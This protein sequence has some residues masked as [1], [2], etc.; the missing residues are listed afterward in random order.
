MT[1]IIMSDSTDPFMSLLD[2]PGEGDEESSDVGESEAAVL[3]AFRQEIY[4]R[5][6]DAGWGFEAAKSVEHGKTDQSLLNHV[7][8]GVFGLA[9][10]DELVGR[11]DG[12]RLD[13]ADL[14]AAMALFTIHDIHKLDPERDSNPETRFD[15]PQEEVEEYVERFGLSQFA[16]RLD[17]RDFQSCAIDHHDDWTANPDGTTVT[18]DELRPFVR[19]ADALA[20][21][22]TPEEATASSVQS[23]V[24]AAYPRAD[25]ELRC[26]VLDDVKGVFTNLIN[27]ATA[28]LLETAGYERLLVYQD[29][30]VY[31]APGDEETPAMDDAFFEQLGQQL[32]TGVQSSHSAYQSPRRLSGN[33][34]TRSQ[35][36]YGI[37][38][39]DFFYAGPRAVLEA[40]GLKG[41]GDA[42]PDS[43]PTDSM[44]ETMEALEA[45]LPFD[46]DRN[47]APVGYA[48]IVYTV[49]RAFVDP[50]LDAR[51]S[52]TSALAAT[53]QIFGASD[54]VTEGLLTAADEIDLTAGGKWDYAYGIGQ[55]LVDEGSPGARA[56]AHRIDEGLTEFDGNWPETVEAAHVGTLRAEIEAYLRRIVSVD[57]ATGSS[58]PS[59]SD[60]F[61]QYPGKR[62]GKICTLCNRGTTSRRKSDL[63][64]PKSLTT[65]QAGYSNDIAVDAGKPDDLLVCM[66]CQIELSLRETGSARREGGRLF[67]HLIPDYFYTPFSWRLLSGLTSELKGESRTELGGLAESLLNIEG[68][69]GGLGS[70]LD[71]LTSEDTGR[72]MI[73]TLDQG[74]D[75]TKQYGA[76]T[77]GYFKP[78]DNDTEYQFFGAFVALALGAY[79][80]LRVL[81]SESPVPDLRGRDFR[82][83]AR[84]G[85]G[86][87]QVHQFYG[88]EV[89]LSALRSRLRAAA[90]LVRLG[91]GA[92]REDALFA[93]Y[94]RVTR[95]QLLPGSYLLKRIAQ[96]DDSRDARYLLE[97]ARALDEETGISTH[98][99]E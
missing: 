13:N 86:F 64:A 89:P 7:C 73:E 75:P 74:F 99:H 14:R 63:E 51:E 37:N 58:G 85:G 97:E 96:A 8:N 61:E 4:P 2:L 59:L 56:L 15:S 80:G 62:R 53:S 44:A 79:A 29:G 87:T 3:E 12:Y 88:E 9:R 90:A 65:L 66:P 92:E 36:F 31:L 84:L 16:E 69:E 20:S 30:C 23:A 71:S 77:L 19:L 45:Y 55:V 91:Y 48:R 6:V 70:F 54:A 22:E 21:C 50:V 57:G 34:S 27:A 41:I 24:S 49:K 38:E 60:P 47:R 46:I 10:F 1:V 43:D 83:F 18:F 95:N 42:D 32:K 52:D 72:S 93:K 68:G 78:K 82:S 26:H 40:I 33:L 39:Q 28:D 17:A 98:V 76:R 67:I 11:F 81:V 35:G 25:F 94:L 5:L